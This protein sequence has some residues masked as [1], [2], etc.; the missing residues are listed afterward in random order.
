MEKEEILKETVKIIRQYL[1]TDC[2]ILLFGSWA[3]GTALDTSDLDIA[4]DGPQKINQEVMIK[5]KAA[6]EGIMTLRKVDV[7]DLNSV[8][9][10]FKKNILDHAQIIDR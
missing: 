2:K 6:I 8:D 3:K 7:V 9:E 4:I 10:E 1:P 5:I